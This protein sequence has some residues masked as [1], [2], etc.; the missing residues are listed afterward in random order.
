MIILKNKTIASILIVNVFF[1]VFIV[2]SFA[3]EA[4]EEEILKQL[5]L[6]A[7]VVAQVQK[8]YLDYPDA[9]ETVYAAIKGMLT[10]LDPYSEFLDEEAYKRMQTNTSGT[11]GG[12]G[13]YI[14]IRMKRLTVISPIEDT[15]AYKAGVSAGDQISEIDGKSTVGIS[16]ESAVQ[17]LRGEPGTSVTIT[18]IREG[19]EEPL[20][21]TIVR[22][23]ITIQTVK[24]RILHGDI[25]YLRVTSFTETTAA[26]VDKAF[27]EF[28]KHNLNGIILDLR[29]NPGGLLSSAVNV[30]SHFVKEGSLIVYTQGRDKSKKEEFFAQKALTEKKYPLVVLVNRG[31]ASGSE[32]VAGAIKDN[33]SGLVMGTRTFGKA[34]VQKIFPMGRELSLDVAVKLTVAHYY[35]PSGR[36]IHKLGIKP[37]ITYPPLSTAEAKTFWK[38]RRSD[39]VKQFIEESGDDVLEKLEAA[40]AEKEKEA[41][42]QI[43]SQYQTFVE[44]LAKDQIVLGDDLVKLAIALETTNDKDEYEFDPQIQAAINYLHAYD[45]FLSGSELVETPSTE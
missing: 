22:D 15:P 9:K 32:I 36:D 8:D 19:E 23:I 38:L 31:S 16:I 29:N 37:H 3:Q 35:T 41:Q 12:L 6:F 21:F 26:D 11:F 14:G 7:E 2:N 43:V 40:Q 34:S 1:A 20:K 44:N 33:K 18:V 45:V 4:N 30:A 27:D 25:G 39:E 5:T 42:N 10:T 13:M 28:E 24:H 17:K